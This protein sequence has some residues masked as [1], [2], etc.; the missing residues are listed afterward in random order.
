M[1]VEVKNIKD[2]IWSLLSGIPDPEIP[3]ISI[4]ELGVVR[5]IEVNKNGIII[6]I[7]PTYSGC[8]AMKVFEDDIISTL[9]R[10]GHK[11]IKIKTIYSPAWTSDWLGDEAKQ[12]LKKYG[13]APPRKTSED[14]NMLFEEDTKKV[15]CPYCDSNNTKL[16]SQFSSTACKALHFC[17]QCQQPFEYFKCI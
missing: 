1:T 8:P 6:S 3:V 9:T 16:T 12:K 10:E 15:P 4:T 14:K 11:N 17:N 7:T 2:Q 13:I 5:D